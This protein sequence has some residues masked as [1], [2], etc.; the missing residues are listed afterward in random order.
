MLIYTLGIDIGS[1]TSKAVLLADGH[2]VIAS[3]LVKAGTGTRGPEEAVDGVLT[4]AGIDRQLV[5]YA[6][7]TGYGRV[8]YEGADAEV[9][10]ITCHARGVHFLVPEARTIIDIGGQD[11]KAIRLDLH[12]RVVDFVMNEK[13]AAGTGRFLEVMAQALGYE[14]GDLAKLGEKSR[15]VVPIS[16]T[17]TVFAESEII[18]HLAAKKQVEDIVAGIHHSIARRIMGLVGRLGF[19]EK[20]VLTGGVAKNWGVQK[21]LEELSR[22][23]LTVPPEPQLTGALGAALIAWDRHSV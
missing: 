22:H 12:G 9:S 23:L 15:E 16:S 17:C 8:T 18:S 7:V 4:S 10:E 19:V 11:A 20:V 1:I 13:C 6:V 2:R 5:K 14:V 3:S 21:A